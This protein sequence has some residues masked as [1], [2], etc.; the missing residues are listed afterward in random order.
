MATVKKSDFA[1]H[2]HDRFGFPTAT[3][4]RIVDIIFGEITESLT[5]GEEVKITNFGTF[6]IRSKRERMGRNP[7][8][9]RPAVIAAR[10]VPSFRAAVGFRE[11][12]SKSKNC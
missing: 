6:G 1:K 5:R 12:I 9:G 3:A 2:I 7:K 11:K 4:E 8:T 10:R